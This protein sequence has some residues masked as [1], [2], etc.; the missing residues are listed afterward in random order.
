MNPQMATQSL[1][2]LFIPRPFQLALPS[3]VVVVVVVVVHGPL[4]R[5]FFLSFS[6]LIPFI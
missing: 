3:V 4:G 5:L 2:A 6:S 1:L